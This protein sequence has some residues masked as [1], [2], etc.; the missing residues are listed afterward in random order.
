M[1]TDHS[2]YPTTRLRR[3]R[4][5]ASIRALVRETHLAPDDFILPIILCE[6]KAL[7]E[8]V[9]LMPG[10]YRHSPDQA[11]S[12]ARQA[13]DC[14][15]KAVML[16]PQT[17]AH[18]RNSE[19]SEAFNPDNLVCKATRLL[20]EHI[21]DLLIICDVALDPYTDH[22]HDGLLR[23]DV[24]VNDET[25]TALIRQALVQVEAGCDTIAP[26]DM[27]DGR[28]GA[29]RAALDQHGFSD[30][31]LLSYA[32]K[33]ASQFYGPFREALGCDQLLKGD[34]KTYQMDPANRLEALR[35]VALDIAEGADQIMVKPAM[36]SLDVVAMVKEQFKI[37]TFAYQVSGEYAM[38]AFAA[39]AGAFDFD[40]AQMESL[41][42]IR[43]AGADAII[44]YYALDAAKH[45]Q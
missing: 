41:T 4:A 10:V 19:A 17:P 3:N 23:G 33:Y 37:P 31:R 39:Q 25:N 2:Q 26:S 32:V 20:R 7:S 16:F 36:P 9:A 14:G 38:L 44:S 24:I 35:E 30:I 22:G 8:P 18:L 27:M 29:I 43:R 34:K 21:P 40:H 28:I 11:V 13:W 1:I 15:I 6:G 42:A 45:C 5:N 12:L